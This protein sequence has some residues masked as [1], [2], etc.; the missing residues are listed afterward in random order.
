MPQ[1]DATTR[2]FDALAQK[3]HEPLLERARGTLRVEL[4]NGRRVDRWFVS[5]DRGDVSVSR[6]N[7]AADATL[8]AD[9]A[10]FDGIASGKVNAM[11]AVLR[12]AVEIDGDQELLV[13]VQRLFPSPRKRR[14][15]T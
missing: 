5:V 1:A 8:R 11:A 2:Y 3:G 9:R 7:A 14:R 10:V 6:K 15:R 13:L 12:G 4:V